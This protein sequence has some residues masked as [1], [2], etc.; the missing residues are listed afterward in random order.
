MESCINFIVC[1]TGNYWNGFSFGIKIL[2]LSPPWVACL[3]KR[4]VG[5]ARSCVKWWLRR[6][7]MILIWI[8]WHYG[9]SWEPLK[10][11][12]NNK[13]HKHTH[14]YTFIR[15]LF[16]L[17]FSTMV[18]HFVIIPQSISHVFRIFI[19][20]PAVSFCL[21]DTWSHPDLMS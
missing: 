12:N 4:T 3:P 18:S 11:N 15:R 16:F 13:P 21:R 17:S 7:R 14:R 6:L 20:L 10:N 9:D 2:H 8:S 1:N 19:R 5:I